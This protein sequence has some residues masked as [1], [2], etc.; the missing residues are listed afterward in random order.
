MTGKYQIGI[1]QSYV[2]GI[3]ALVGQ[4]PSWGKSAPQK[5]VLQL[6]RDTLTWSKV[7]SSLTSVLRSSANN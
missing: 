5:C 4:T 7:T 6:F 3:W 1:A 2:A